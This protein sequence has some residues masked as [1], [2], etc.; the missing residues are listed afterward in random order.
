LFPYTT[1]FRSVGEQVEV[2]EDAG[3]PVPGHRVVA[4]LPGV[5]RVAAG[6]VV[7]GVAAGAVADVLRL[8]PVDHHPLQVEPGDVH[9]AV[10]RAGQRLGVRAGLPGL[11]QALGELLLLAVGLDLLAVD[12]VDR[13]EEH[14]QAGGE[15]QLADGAQDAARDVAAGEAAAVAA[16]AAA[17]RSGAPVRSA[18]TGGNHVDLPVIASRMRAYPAA[19]A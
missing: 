11:L 6:H 9:P 1:L 5:R 19:R 8:H 12:L 4:R 10:G 17:R 18:L 3:R 14:H 16:C 15:Q 2:P 7:V 13:E